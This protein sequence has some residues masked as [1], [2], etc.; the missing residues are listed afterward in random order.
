M[1][2][3]NYRNGFEVTLQ[4]HMLELPLRWK[5]PQQI[6]VNSMSDL[7]HAG[8]PT[9]YIQR[10]F[11]VM[12]EAKWHTF[13]VL[14][15]RADRLEE[16]DREL[17]WPPNVWMAVSV[18]SHAVTH[19][20]D[21]LRATRAQVKFLSI[22]RTRRNCATTCT[23]DGNRPLRLVE[24]PSITAASRESVNPRAVA[25][26]PDP[27]EPR[28]VEMDHVS[29]ADMPVE[30]RPRERMARGGA[31]ALSDAEL[32]A[33]LIE[34][35]RRGRSSLDIAREIVAD[36]LLAVARREWIP[37]KAV[38]S[39]GASRVARI[40]AALE[41]GRR[42]AT[43]STTSAEPIR[44]PAIVARRLMATYGHRVQETL[45]GIYLDARHRI[46]SEREIFVG[47]LKAATVSP[48]DVFRFALSDHAAA[49]IVFHN[50]P[51]GDP[52]PSPQDLAFTQK[53]ANIGEQLGVD[54]I[55]HLIVTSN[56]FLS[57]KQNGHM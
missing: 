42:I 54:V 14:T 12:R 16:I 26:A 22:G 1:G 15:K 8:V 55:D 29:I 53:L 56:N 11:A 34:P 21:S 13:Q 47:S 32:M 40:G 38:G 39:L 31:V 52:S 10:V 4:P 44:E 41:L 36:G 23:A 6:F 9:P 51:S 45:G 20:I 57:F 28:G 50:H 30:E 35:G 37:G 17:D 49:V 7:F 46:I 27:R 43:L 3:P 19:R 2:Q 48:R 25:L 24:R 5:K 33:L 18:E